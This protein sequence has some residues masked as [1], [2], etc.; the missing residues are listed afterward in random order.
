MLS[1]Q[2]TLDCWEISSILCSGIF[3]G[4]SIK[5]IFE[6]FHWVFYEILLN[7]FVHFRG[8]PYEGV[9]SDKSLRREYRFVSY[10]NNVIQTQMPLFF[11]IATIYPLLFNLTG[12]LLPPC[13]FHV[14][15]F[16]SAINLIGWTI[17]MI[18][19]ILIMMTTLRQAQESGSRGDCWQLQRGCPLSLFNMPFFHSP[20]LLSKKKLVH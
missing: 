20:W 17:R 7:A 9:S 4:V 3:N 2:Q 18:L 1:H 16:V 19:I 11:T 10:S 8:D 15:L 5:F 14:C 6:Y 13:N 12:V